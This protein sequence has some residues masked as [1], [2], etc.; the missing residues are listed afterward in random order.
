MDNF[1]QNAY[2]VYV[3]DESC[4]ERSSEKRFYKTR[5]GADARFD[6]L[7]R[8]LTAGHKIVIMVEIATDKAVRISGCKS[9]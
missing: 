8:S 1:F 4:V 7:L 2:K 5:K 9:S 3:T 6:Q